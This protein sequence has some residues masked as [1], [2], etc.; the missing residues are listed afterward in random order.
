MRATWPS[1]SSAG[2]KIV[3]AAAGQIEVVDA[4]GSGLT[5]LTPGAYDSDPAWSPDGSKI[6]FITGGDDHVSV[7]NPDGSD[8]RMVSP[9]PSRSPAWSPDGRTIVFSAKEGGH[10]DVYAVRRRRD[11]A[12]AA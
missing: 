5:Q 4:D 3:F 8:V 2:D 11:G 10:A 7:M 6:A 12:S 1:W 9:L